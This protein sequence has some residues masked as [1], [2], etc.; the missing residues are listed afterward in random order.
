MILLEI[1]MPK[2]ILKPLKAMEQVFFG[3]W[4]CIYDPSDWW[5]KWIEGK[6]LL[7]YS[8][9]IVGLEGVPHFF[10]RIPESRRNAVEANIYSQYPDV[11]ISVVDDYVK[12][13][14]P[15]APNKDWDLWGADYELLKSDAY[16][17]R[18]Y[19]RFFEEKPDAP[20]EEKRIDPLASLLEGIAKFGAGEQIWVQITAFPVTVAENNYVARA[21]EEAN[22]LIGR[23]KK[24]KSKSMVGEAVSGVVLGKKVEEKK[25]D[26]LWPEMMLSPGERD[27]ISAIEKKM[28][29]YSFEC[30]IRFLYVA[31]RD[32]F[33][34]G[35]KAVPLGFFSQFSTTDLNGMKPFPPTM[36]KIHKSW[37]L[38]L[39]LIRERRVYVRKRT[40]F[41]NYIK[42]LPPLFPKKKV[43]T[44]VL[45]SE[46]LATLFHFPGKSVVSAPSI[47]RVETKKGE[48]PVDLPSE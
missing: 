30:F 10:I 29:Q 20:K 34:G 4:G 24:E 22:K 43:K 42:R 3:L 41:R 16:P 46:E 2:E 21:K 40:F 8:F 7:A 28:G 32:S 45:G 19:S 31:K 25:Q 27:V 6:M 17:I 15:D 23:P 18:T 14:P 39:N 1:K 36:T 47:S 13:V 11:E 44:F 5:E 38:P 33:F 48:A 37:F 35:A 26:L 12:A 9:E